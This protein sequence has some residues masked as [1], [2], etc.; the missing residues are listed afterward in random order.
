MKRPAPTFVYWQP[1]TT[2]EE[3]LGSLH[4][5]AERRYGQPHAREL[6]ARLSQVAGWLELIGQQPLEL[7]DEEPDD[8]R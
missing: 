3:I 8:G 7:L 1:M 4:N 6:D 2:S 5:E